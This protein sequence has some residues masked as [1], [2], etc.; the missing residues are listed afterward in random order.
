T[1]YTLLKQYDEPR[2][3]LR[4]RYKYILV[5]EYQD[6]SRLQHEIFRLLASESTKICAVGDD[7]QSI[8][9]FRGASVD[10]IFSFDKDFPN[11]KAFRIGENFRSTEGIV[12]LSRRL[13]ENNKRRSDKD[14][15]SMRG[16]GSEVFLIEGNTKKESGEIICQAIKEMMEARLV[17]S[18]S[19]IVLLFRSVKW[20]FIGGGYK[21]VLMNHNIPCIIHKNGSFFDN[22]A[23][24]YFTEFLDLIT[25]DNDFER[26]RFNDLLPR[27]HLKDETLNSFLEHTKITMTLE[28]IA[29][30]HLKDTYNIMDPLDFKNLS[31]IYQLALNAKKDD[32]HKVLATLYTLFDLSDH[33]SMALSIKDSKTLSQIAYLTLLAQS[34]ETWGGQSLRPFVDQLLMFRDKRTLEEVLLEEESDGVHVSTIH[35][36]KGLEYKAVFVC[37]FDPVSRWNDDFHIPQQ[38]MTRVAPSSDR[39]DNQN[40]LFYVALTRAK[41]FLFL[42]HSRTNKYGRPIRR[43]TFIEKALRDHTLKPYEPTSFRHPSKPFVLRDNPENSSI[44]ISYTAI[45]SYTTCPLKYQLENIYHFKCPETYHTR[46]GTVIHKVLEKIHLSCLH[47]QKVS[48]ESI[49]PLFRRQLKGQC[50]TRRDEESEAYNEG[51]KMLLSY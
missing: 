9:Q 34:Y 43:N 33:F 7:D 6:T 25:R 5:D 2:N 30:E 3:I 41:D 16:K 8:Y 35:S 14:L 48:E 49:L 11:V 12:K 40:R 37:D 19:D 38:V 39:Q 4:N 1:V 17:T 22:D 28:E 20:G 46:L 27:L 24:R 29:P 47:S 45:Q 36:V 50:F 44:S 32:P 26:S 10:H 15:T 23:I 21:E 18:Y 42:C 13:I 51:C 31:S